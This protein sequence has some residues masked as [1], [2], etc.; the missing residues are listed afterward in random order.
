[1]NLLRLLLIALAVWII[2]VLIRNHR[3]AGL[4]KPPQRP[5]I[6][7]IVPCAVCDT[8][9]PESEALHEGEHYYCCA[10][11]RDQARETRH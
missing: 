10:E 11:H 3:R 9:I 1:M 7:T 5:S 4:K 6:D 8:H 2:L